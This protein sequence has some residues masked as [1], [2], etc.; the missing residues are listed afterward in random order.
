MSLPSVFSRR[1]SSGGESP[2]TVEL[3]AGNPLLV[4]PLL[5]R[6]PSR[7]VNRTSFRALPTSQSDKV[8]RCKA[9]CNSFS[10]DHECEQHHVSREQ[11]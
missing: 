5:E 3:E 11:N 7:L 1:S 8:I 6:E 2:G 4:K 10:R 9:A